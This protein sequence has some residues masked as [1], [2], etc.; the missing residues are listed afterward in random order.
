MGRIKINNELK[1]TTISITLDKV[2]FTGLD[3]LN[4]KSKSQ[5]VNWLL[6]EHLCSMSLLKDE[7][8]NNESK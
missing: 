2:V 6:R 8:G 4:V 5:L 7:E 3:E 1:K